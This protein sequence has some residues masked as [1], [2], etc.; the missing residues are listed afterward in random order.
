MRITAADILPFDRSK[1]TKYIG[2]SR[3]EQLR[4][5]YKAKPGEPWGKTDYKG[6]KRVEAPGMKARAKVFQ[7]PRR[8]GRTSSAVADFLVDK[9]E[10]GWASSPTGNDCRTI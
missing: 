1:R 10:Y 5:K 8:V 6:P 9:S 2:P 3:N 7:V 4:E